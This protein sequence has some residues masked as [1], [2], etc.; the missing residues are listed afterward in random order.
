MRRPSLWRNH[1]FLRLW[2]AQSV[3]LIGTQVTT[4]ALP[5]VAILSLH[6]TPLEVG[7][8]A[9]LPW[10][11]FLVLGLPVG[12]F[13]DRLPR[14]RL[15]IGADLLRALA[16]GMIPLTFW[17]GRP[18]LA[19][20][21]A[22]GALVGIG[23]VFYEIANA[24]YLPTLVASDALV[25]GNSKLAATEGAAAV[26]GPALGGVLIGAFG[27]A[28][29][30]IADILSYCFSGVLL[31][32]IRTREPSVAGRGWPPLRQMGG[33]MREGIVYLW[34]TPTVLTLAVVSTLQNLGDS[35]ATAMLLVLLYRT[36]HLAP[37][38]VGLAFTLGSIGFVAGAVIAQPVTRRL[39]VGRLLLVSSLCGAITFLLLPLAAWGT[40]FF[41]VVG[42]RIL[43]GLHIPTYNINVVS[44]RQAVIPLQIQ[45][46][47][48]AATRTLGFGVLSIGP[49]VG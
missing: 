19:V 32:M 41:W 45:G 46:R 5:A 17:L 24:A 26:G 16:L 4:L 43:Y 44:L 2:G 9:A 18:S 20:L 29:A 39:G 36:L 23:N 13:V 33:D 22:A 10:A 7:V 34:R 28:F 30:I 1:D 40:P 21:Y 15:M 42:T 12:V 35:M 48:N 38:L 37:S 3:S 25:E 14:R 47:L 31:S 49:I 27:S 8:L 6:A 11:A